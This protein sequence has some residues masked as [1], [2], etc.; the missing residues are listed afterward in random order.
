MHK[1][2]KKFTH[3]AQSLTVAGVEQVLI[4]LGFCFGKGL[5]CISIHAQR[6]RLTALHCM[7]ARL[8]HKTKCGKY[9]TH[10]CNKDTLHCS[11]SAR[12][13]GACFATHHPQARAACFIYVKSYY[14]THSLR[15]THDQANK[16]T[17]RHHLIQHCRRA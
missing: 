1:T 15:G 2:Q 5:F 10:C 11:A 9:V 4:L 6:T 14:S 16:A 3:A 8:S 13:R 17:N 7:A 12:H